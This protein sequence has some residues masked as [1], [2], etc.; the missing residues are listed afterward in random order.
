MLTNGCDLPI[1]KMDGTKT[2]QNFTFY[3]HKF[4]CG[5]DLN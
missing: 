1:T 4:V 5:I 3:V 2:K